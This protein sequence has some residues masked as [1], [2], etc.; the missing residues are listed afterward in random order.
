MR[1]RADVL[2]DWL[3]G[4]QAVLR[5]AEPD[6]VAAVV[7]RIEAAGFHAVPIDFVSIANKADLMTAMRAALG[8][9]AW[10]GANWDALG[11][12][13]FGPETPV[14][15]LTVLLLCLPPS[16]PALSASDFAILLQIIEDVAGSGRSTLKGAVVL[17]GGPFWDGVGA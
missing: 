3:A 2:G 14:E 12:A 9:D 13:L 4:D 1:P 6:S 17:G 15:R 10:F 7:E 8:L 11:D 5:L 16:G